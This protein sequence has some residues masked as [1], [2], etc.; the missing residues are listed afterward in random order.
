MKKMILKTLFLITLRKCFFTK[1]RRFERFTPNE[2]GDNEIYVRDNSNYVRHNENYLRDN[3]IYLPA[4][5]TH[6]RA[7]FQ[8]VVIMV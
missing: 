6:F 5:D 1:N 8:C 2:L 4:N 7:S 3:K